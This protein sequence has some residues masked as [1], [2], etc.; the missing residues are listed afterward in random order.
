MPVFLVVYE[1]CFQIA[2]VNF[3]F[4]IFSLFKEICVRYF[5]FNVFVIFTGK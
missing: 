4:L 3:V 2:F 1:N 5:A